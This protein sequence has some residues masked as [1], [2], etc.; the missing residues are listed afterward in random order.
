MKKTA[1]YK[2]NLDATQPIPWKQKKTSLH[3]HVN[4]VQLDLEKKRKKLGNY[5]D[6]GF[7]FI[8]VEVG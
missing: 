7:N 8:M 4:M 2:F 1:F 6:Y 3:L 5:F